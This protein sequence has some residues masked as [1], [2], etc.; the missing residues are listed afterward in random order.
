MMSSSE[1][2]GMF[3]TKRLQDELVDGI[4]VHQAGHVLDDPSSQHQGGVV[5]GACCPSGYT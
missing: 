4:F 2:K 3:E 1:R 5:V